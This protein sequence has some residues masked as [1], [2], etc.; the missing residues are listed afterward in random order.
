MS[1]VDLNDVT[2]EHRLP[3]VWLSVL[4]ITALFLLALWWMS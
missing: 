3:P 2:V 4:A 1:G